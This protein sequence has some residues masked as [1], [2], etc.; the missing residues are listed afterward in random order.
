MKKG[1]ILLGQLSCTGFGVAVATP[2]P[3]PLIVGGT[4][5]DGTNSELGLLARGLA[6]GI[7]VLADTNF[8]IDLPLPNLGKGGGDRFVLGMD[9]DTQHARICGGPDLRCYSC[10]AYGES[11][12]GLPEDF[13]KYRKKKVKAMRCTAVIVAKDSYIS[14]VV[15]DPRGYKYQ[16][17]TL[18]STGS[19]RAKHKKARRK[20]TPPGYGYEGIRVQ[21]WNISLE[22]IVPEESISIPIDPGVDHRAL[23]AEGNH[24]PKDRSR[25]SPK[26]DSSQ[27]GRAKADDDGSTITLMYYLTKRAM[28]QW[29]NQVYANCK[30]PNPAALVTMVGVVTAYG[31][32]VLSNS[33]IDYVYEPVHI[34]VDEEHDE[35]T[36]ATTRERLD[37]ITASETA[38]RL[39]NRYGADLVVEVHYMNPAKGAGG[40]GYV[41]RTFPA[42]ELGFSSQGG[43][44]QLI[45]YIIAHEIGQ[46]MGLQYGY[47]NCDECFMTIMS[48]KY[49]CEAQ[50]CRSVTEI[51]YFSNVDV[52]YT[53]NRGTFAMGNAANDNSATLN[54][55]RVGVAMHRFKVPQLLLESPRSASAYET[56]GL[57]YLV[58]SVIAKDNVEVNNIEFIIG[59]AMEIELYTATGS[60]EGN[61]W[62]DAFW[63]DPHVAED[64][65][66]MSDANP[67]LNLGFAA[68]ESFPTLT[69]SK[70]SATSFKIKHETTSFMQYSSA[71][72][73][74][75]GD[76]YF[77]NDHLQVTVGA[78]GVKGYVYTNPASLQGALRYTVAKGNTVVVSKGNQKQ[79]CIAK[80]RKVRNAQLVKIRA[81]HR[82]R[83]GACSR[84]RSSSKIICQ[85]AQKI[86][87][88][89]QISS[90]AKKMKRD[91]KTCTVVKEEQEKKCTTKVGL[92]T[93]EV[94]N[95]NQKNECKAKAR[96][97][98]VAF[99]DKI[100]ARYRTNMKVCTSVPCQTTHQ[101]RRNAQI[102]NIGR[103]MISRYKA[104][105]RKFG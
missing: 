29:T 75:L 7:G 93:C 99:L 46:N 71:S 13:V 40:I 57:E 104:C 45:D 96:K 88:D 28:C 69:L 85:T 91:F 78:F 39:R 2:D 22:K 30:K 100:K 12:S 6:G 95:R 97:V 51:P 21:D 33:N 23:H 61:E 68:F 36:S 43:Q 54:L 35:G 50:G 4:F 42:R 90:A 5:D 80:A 70:G 62:D 64:V 20:K 25:V 82:T 19:I 11:S 17:S 47:N 86:R 34:H 10:T 59:G 76:V 56:A 27:I 9:C 103:K 24:I 52:K 1:L 77:E 87:V 105:D 32:L 66:P 49:H 73:M 98:R 41:P 83:M 102:S 18:L 44:F 74:A 8:R 101:T 3:P 72:G 37:W 89:T 79:A 65:V 58:F 84:K 81:Q 38:A 48:Y 26:T 63:G 16:I 14:G 60:F 31:N 67:L 55:S 15:T 53:N 94:I 92:K